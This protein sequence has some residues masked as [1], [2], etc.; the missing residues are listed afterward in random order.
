MIATETRTTVGSSLARSPIIAVVRTDTIEAAREQSHALLDSGLELLEITFTVPGAS[1]LVRELLEARSDDSSTWIGMG[2]V[3][4]RARAEE[5]LAAGSEFIVSPNVAPDVAAAAREAGRFLVMG[6]LTPTEIVSA[7]ELGADIVKVYPL[8]AVGGTGYLEVVRGPLFDVD[9]L[10]AGGFGVD[11]IPS[12]R[13]A[14]A[15]AFGM[16]A[17]LLL[18][19]DGNSNANIDRALRLARGTA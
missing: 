1:S 8:P 4:T 11:E 5:A 9:M 18:G 15:I 2:S 6:A 3:S 17:P 13:A 16:A 14:G 10:A 19:T 12:Y 7:I